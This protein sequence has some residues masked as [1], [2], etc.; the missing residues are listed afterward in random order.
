MRWFLT[1]NRKMKEQRINLKICFKL[2][3]TPYAMLVR[4]HEDQELSLKLK[5]ALKGKKFDDIPDIKRNVTRF[6]NSIPKE[7]FSERFQDMYSRSQWCIVMGGYYFEGQ[8]GS[9]S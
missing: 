7:D 1:E 3:E 9:F 4:V 5:L 8:Q 2:G 6:L